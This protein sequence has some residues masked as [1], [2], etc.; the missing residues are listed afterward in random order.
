MGV[1]ISKER[2]NLDFDISVN[3]NYQ[4]NTVEPLLFDTYL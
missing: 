2:I 1:V 3:D 4:F